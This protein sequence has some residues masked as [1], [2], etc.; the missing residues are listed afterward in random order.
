[1]NTSTPP[2]EEE[3]EFSYILSSYSL[4]WMLFVRSLFRLDRDMDKIL[5][6]FLFKNFPPLNCSI[7]KFCEKSP[8]MMKC[9]SEKCLSAEAEESADGVAALAMN[10]SKREF[11]SQ[12]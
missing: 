2:N 11:H 12:Q 1:V 6:I 10:L 3:D 4:L 9:F 8:C 7:F 5:A